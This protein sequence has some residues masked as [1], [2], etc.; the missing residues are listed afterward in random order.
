MYLH[1]GVSR[2]PLDLPVTAT[3]LPAISYVARQLPA[4]GGKIRS[5]YA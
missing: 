2:N 5:M 3:A 1:S 4:A